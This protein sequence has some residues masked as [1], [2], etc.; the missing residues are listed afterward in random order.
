MNQKKNKELENK[1]NE[2][3]E[4]EN[5]KKDDE[6]TI[7]SNGKKIDNL[8]KDISILQNNIK[9]LENKNNILENKNLELE[10][11]IKDLKVNN[12]KIKLEFVYNE[13]LNIKPIKK[14]NE[15]QIIE[16]FSINSNNKNEE[17][18]SFLNSNNTIFFNRKIENILNYISIEIRD[19]KYLLEEGWKIN[20]Y[21][22]NNFKI[23]E[24]K[25]LSIGFLGDYSIGKTYFIKKIFNLDI[26][27][28][29]TENI[30]Y[31]Y[32]NNNIRIIDIPG[33]NKSLFPI[34]D[35][36]QQNIIETKK[37]DFIIQKFVL[38]NSIIN[39][40]IIDSF[41]LNI[42]KRIGKLKI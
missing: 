18:D 39:I 23:E 33:S 40:M 34:D 10:N 15:K 4:F 19:T 29:S 30:N 36:L 20:R 5:K 9:E 25:G 7:K 13:D 22:E 37:K 24:N 42:K 16:N 14:K 26:P 1:I 3:N 31:Y 38:D 2:F 6:N 41:N 12:Q 27:I 11:K 35:K 28:E 21:L 8:N 17:I 32:L